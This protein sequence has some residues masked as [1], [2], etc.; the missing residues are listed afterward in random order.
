MKA[1]K[2]QLSQRWSP[3]GNEKES[4]RGKSSSP[5]ACGDRRRSPSLSKWNK[6][7]IESGGTTMWPSFTLS[8]S[9]Q[10]HVAFKSFVWNYSWRLD[11]SPTC[12]NWWKTVFNKNVLNRNPSIREA[13]P[14]SFLAALSPTLYPSAICSLVLFNGMWEHVTVDVFP[15]LSCLV[16]A[17]TPRLL[18]LPMIRSFKSCWAWINHGSSQSRSRPDRCFPVELCVSVTGLRA[19]HPWPMNCVCPHF[20]SLSAPAPLLSLIGCHVVGHRSC[21][22]ALVFPSFFQSFCSF[23]M[24]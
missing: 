4:A 7:R 18:P 22:L 1:Q 21:A 17:G 9:L 13:E 10:S 19:S 14:C 8:S 16:S 5:S 11:L 12:Q 6:L 20:P 2:Q 24:W 15:L 23:F 3:V